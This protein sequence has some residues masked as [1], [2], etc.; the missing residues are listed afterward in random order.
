MAN[1]NTLNVK[2]ISPTQTIFDGEAFSISSVNSLGKFDILPYHA[3][4]ITL[5]QKA[6]IFLRVRKKDSDKKAELGLE[7]FDDLFGKNIEE[8]KYEFDLAIIYTKDNLVKIYT[9][10]QPQF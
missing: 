8:V 9:N 7:M 4:F 1:K 3:N 5:V 6:P 2:I 10:I